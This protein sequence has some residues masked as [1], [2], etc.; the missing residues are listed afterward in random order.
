M[1]R[2][3]SP[4]LGHPADRPNTPRRAP[5]PTPPHTLIVE[6]TNSVQRQ[7][8]TSSTSS[9]GSRWAVMAS[10][11]TLWHEDGS[12]AGVRPPG[13]RS[14]LCPTSQLLAGLSPQA[15]GPEHSCRHPGLPTPLPMCSPKPS[16]GTGPPGSW[17]SAGGKA[18]LTG[19]DLALGPTDPAQ[20]P[21]ASGP[22]LTPPFP[23]CSQ[24]HPVGR[25]G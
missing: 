23:V 2:V 3:Q 16:Q 8:L 7:L 25:A 6:Y 14:G 13:H 20:A 9:L 21:P 19:G 5:D 22:P 24:R 10:D 17:P 18:V 15:L 12:G 1:K 4:E 11:F